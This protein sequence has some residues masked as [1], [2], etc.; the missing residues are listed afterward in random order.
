MK[1]IYSLN[2]TEEG[3]K[4]REGDSGV[5]LRG[6][7]EGRYTN[8]LDAVNNT[9]TQILFPLVNIEFPLV[10]ISSSLTLIPSKFQ[11]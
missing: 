9:S 6:E 1:E 4:E 10:N 3:E 8:T 7:S 5:K 2:H 11:M